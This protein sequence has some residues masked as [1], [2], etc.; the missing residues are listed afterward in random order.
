MST[1]DTYT[2]GSCA[3]KAG[4]NQQQFMSRCAV[5]AEMKTRF[6]DQTSRSRACY[7]MWQTGAAVAKSGGSG[8]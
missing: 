7:A 8:S 6:L 4:E 1:D 2:G 5:D 3:P